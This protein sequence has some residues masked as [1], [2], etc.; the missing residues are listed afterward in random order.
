MK[1]AIQVDIGV[2]KVTEVPEPQ[3]GPDQVKVKIA[4]CG[5]CGTDVEIL[6]GRFSPGQPASGGK[7]EPMINGHE[8]SGTI[9]A[10]GS[11][12][13]RGY[14]VGQ[15]VAMNFRCPC[16]A[17]Y[18]C[19]NGME[20]F[21]LDADFATGAFAEYAV[22]KESA[23]F[24]LP[25]DI[26][27]EHGALLEPVS[28]ALHTVDRANIRPGS[29]VAISGAGPIGLLVLELARISGAARVLVSEPVAR[30]RQLARKLG[31]DAVVDPLQEDLEEVSRNL[32]GGRG[33][34]VVIEASGNLGA[35]RQAISLAGK[36]GTVVW[37]AVYP[38]D[39]EV[40][41]SP[42]HMFASELTIR[43]VFLSPYSFHRSLEL[44]PRLDL[45]PI[46]TDIM[47]LQD[48]EKAFELHKRGNSI[49]ILI[50]P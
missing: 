21:C 41:V 48:I 38:K 18:Y 25:D 3:P 50:K 24:P 42:F 31:A 11:Q 19:R 43:S 20:H 39:A 22:Y 32:T 29:S 12:V 46:I 28:V 5:I 34:D 23:I 15:R 35:A 44:L 4:Y 9:T 13:R 45:K 33:F 26:T 8:A 6:E 10:L 27:L 37:A 36:C 49:K 40:A 14:R 1:A 7:F 16:G 47:P 30:K 2:L 17:C